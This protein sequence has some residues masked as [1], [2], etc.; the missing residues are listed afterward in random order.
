MISPLFG[1]IL[2]ITSRSTLTLH[3]QVIEILQKRWKDPKSV[4]PF[5]SQAFALF[6]INEEHHDLYTQPRIPDRY[7]A[8]SVKGPT[9]DKV[10]S[11]KFPKLLTKNFSSTVASSSGAEF[12]AHSLALKM[13]NYQALSTVSCQT[14][15][16]EALDNVV[17]ESVREPLNK[18]AQ[19]LQFMQA[20]GFYQADLASKGQVRANSMSRAAW[21][22]ETEFS[23]PMKANLL[24][25]PVE[26]GKKSVG[27]DKVKCLMFGS[28][29]ESSAKEVA[30]AI[31]V[32]KDIEDLAKTSQSQSKGYQKPKEGQNSG[33]QSSSFNKNQGGGSWNSGSGSSR[34][35][36]TSSN[37]GGRGG[38]FGGRGGRGGH[39]NWNKK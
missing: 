11:S 27:D 23:K 32:R 2:R 8:L 30:E 24:A 7:V 1:Q 18:L 14:L 9:S 28:N 12:A 36:F 6:K 35:S 3:N 16:K 5:D 20:T 15:L 4:R 25:M 22:E 33:A 38:Q 13:A 17:D 21:L 26:I 37:R 34:G 19:G 39:G 10:L 31:K 29:L